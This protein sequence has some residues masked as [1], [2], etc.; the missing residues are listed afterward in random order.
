MTLLLAATLWAAPKD[1]LRGAATRPAATKPA[2]VHKG[3]SALWGEY[4]KMTTLTE[5]QRA[6]VMQIH[7]QFL[8][9]RRALEAKQEADIAAILGADQVIELRDIRDTAAAQRKRKAADRRTAAIQ[10]QVEQNAAATR[11]T[12]ADRE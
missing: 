5:E 4:A 3:R 10:K 8:T 7:Q 1:E 6:R 2:A 11:P 9:D 12:E